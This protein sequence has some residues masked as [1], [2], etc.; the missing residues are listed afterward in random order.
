MGKVVS[1]GKIGTAHFLIVP[2]DNEYDVTVITPTETYETKTS[3]WQAA[4]DWID[5]LIRKV[6]ETDN[7]NDRYS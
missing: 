4:K 6:E 7:E 3:G 5:N 1:S 2:H